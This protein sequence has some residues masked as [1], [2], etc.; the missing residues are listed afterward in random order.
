MPLSPV[1]LVDMLNKNA[2]KSS[3]FPL[4]RGYCE[5]RLTPNAEATYGVE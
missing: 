1:I 2:F 3:G 5:S 4:K